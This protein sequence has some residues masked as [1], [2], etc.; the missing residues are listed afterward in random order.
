MS[1]TIWKYPLII[2]DRQTIPVPVFSTPLS[3]QF[4]QGVLCLWVEV[5][6][7][8]ELE[9]RMIHVYGTGNPMATKVIQQYVGTAQEPDR[10][11]VWHVYWV[12]A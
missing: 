4:Q 11:L 8:I 5:D 3:V 2:T 9:Q 7:D 12:G 10:Q 6:P 1:R